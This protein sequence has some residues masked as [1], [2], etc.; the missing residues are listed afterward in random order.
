MHFLSDVFLGFFH[1]TWS[2]SLL[3]LRSSS[4]F[5]PGV[6]VICAL[7]F[8]SQYSIPIIY[9]GRETRA[10][11]RE[12]P[13]SPEPILQRESSNQR[14]SSNPLNSIIRKW[15]AQFAMQGGVME[16]GEYVSSN[17][18]G[19]D[20]YYHADEWLDD[21]EEEEAD[22]GEYIGE[23]DLDAFK[24]VVMNRADAEEE[25]E[26]DVAES[27]GT[28]QEDD[29]MEDA[30]GNW[31]L[32]IRRLESN[33]R[34]PVK[35]LVLD[36][37]SFQAFPGHTKQKKQK[38]LRDSVAR[39]RRLLPKV[40][41]IQSQWQAAVWNVVVATND[42][43]NMQAFIELWNEVAPNKQKEEITKERDELVQKI[44]PSLKELANLWKAGEALIRSK[45]DTTL[46]LLTKWWELWNQEEECAGRVGTSLASCRSITKVEKRF[47]S[48]LGEL[49]P[50]LNIDSIPYL[51][52]VAL[53]GS[54]KG[55]RTGNE[56]VASGPGGSDDDNQ[57]G[58]SQSATAVDIPSISLPVTI[59]MYK[60][61][62][63]LKC[64]LVDIK[65]LAVQTIQII[66]KEWESGPAKSPTS[67]GD[68]AGGSGIPE[69]SSLAAVYESYQQKFVRKQDRVGLVSQYDA[70]KCFA[71]KQ[72]SE[73]VYLFDVAQKAA[74]VGH[75]AFTDKGGN[76]LYLAS[77]AVARL[78]D[79]D[80]RK[81]L[82][83]QKDERKRKREIL[84]Q[85]ARDNES[86]N[87]PFND[88]F[89]EVPAFSKDL[90]RV[91]Q[92][93]PGKAEAPRLAPDSPE[94]DVSM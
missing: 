10:P 73:Y 50:N 54:K 11:D 26:D 44:S 62:E 37:E 16:S 86:M 76:P 77:V 83:A 42:A 61:N 87:P 89:V 78:A 5:R 32:L 51:L 53:F 75:Y 14:S 46:S 80:K 17:G 29:D 27:D 60:K 58:E 69:F 13:D 55:K 8:D 24:V 31:Q 35:Q 47:A 93:T 25:S 39:L 12:I 49:I 59:Y 64:R 66:D 72:G 15:E 9:F 7:N 45:H 28:D 21:G 90:F 22:S 65:S 43:A 52:R 38:A 84:E 18:R 20:R 56:P 81:R 3:T 57:P 91:E 92:P 79:A 41:Q 34:D 70:W 1:S 71:V 2:T 48:S 4:L 94:E 30:G 82:E 63:L 23:V 85:K 6:P 36:M 67:G 88:V 74:A 19:D 68:A 33:K 40:N